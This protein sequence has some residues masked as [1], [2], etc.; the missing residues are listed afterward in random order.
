[1]IV[2]R[3]VGFELLETL[4]LLFEVSHLAFIAGGFGRFDVEFVFLDVLVDAFHSRYRPHEPE[5]SDPTIR[6]CTCWSRG[7]GL[8][9]I[10]VDNLRARLNW[11]RGA[12]AVANSR[13]V[14]EGWDPMT[15]IRQRRDRH[16]IDAD[17]RL[18]W[19]NGPEENCYLS[20]QRQW[21]RGLSFDEVLAWKQCAPTGMVSQRFRSP[22]EAC[23]A[24]EHARIIWSHD[25]YLRRMGD[26][27]AE[28]RSVDDY[29]PTVMKQAEARGER[30]R[31]QPWL[32]PE[33]LGPVCGLPPRDLAPCA[34][35]SR[36][37]GG[38]ST[39]ASGPEGEEIAHPHRRQR[40]ARQVAEH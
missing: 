4:E 14:A 15:R 33:P 6:E 7:C 18:F 12:A 38:A 40:S 34:P 8:A 29:K 36:D 25:L 17:G 5:F 30:C 32:L 20:E 23:E 9:L 16:F 37:G 2:F 31:R 27:M 35:Q 10:D 26:Q 24:F 13:K 3:V 28:Q 1:M 11:L 19:I 39:K 21:R 22:Q